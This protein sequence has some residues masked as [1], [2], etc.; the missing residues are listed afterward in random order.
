MGWGKSLGS[1]LGGFVGQGELGGQL[2]DKVSGWLGDTAKDVGAGWVDQKI[3]GIPQPKTGTAGGAQQLDYMNAAF[4]GTNAW[5]RLGQSNAAAGVSAAKQSGRNQ[6]SLQRSEL[7]T[8]ERIADKQMSTQI[9]IASIPYKGGAFAPTGD[10]TADGA[11][12]DT[13][14]MQAREQIRHKLRLLS[15]QAKNLAQRTKTDF[16]TMLTKKAQLEGVKADTYGKKWKAEYANFHAKAGVSREVIQQVLHVFGGIVLG[17]AGSKFAKMVKPKPKGI[18]P[19]SG[20]PPKKVNLKP[21]NQ[22]KGGDKGAYWTIN[23][24]LKRGEK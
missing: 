23:E 3:N 4:P 5:E 11:K 20:P 6:K 1:L 16:E 9:K 10:I 14:I 21:A 15:G 18:P 19:A 12:Y 22:N 17:R 24:R 13:P 8:R 7:S 2:G